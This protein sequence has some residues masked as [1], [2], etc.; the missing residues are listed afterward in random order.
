MDVFS[1]FF[2]ASDFH[3]E[4]KNETFPFL[5]PMVPI[6]SIACLCAPLP[7]RSPGF[8]RSAITR[9]KK[10]GTASDG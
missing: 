7:R 9:R 10:F 3:D 5:E 8:K 4:V 6:P 1:A 2:Y